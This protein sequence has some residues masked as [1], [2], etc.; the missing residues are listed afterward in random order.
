MSLQIKIGPKVLKNYATAFCTPIHHLFSVSLSIGHLPNEWCTYLII[1]ILKA[2]D[3][4]SVKNY[5][6]I[7]LLCNMT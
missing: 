5:K 2:G 1:P 7:S 4:S 6:P 3:R